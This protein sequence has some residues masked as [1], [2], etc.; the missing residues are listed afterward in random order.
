MRIG[1][2]TV[3][4]DEFPR[5]GCTIEAFQKLKPAFILDGTGTVTAGNC[6]GSFYFIKF[7]GDFRSTKNLFLRLGINDGAAALVLTSLS[8]ANRRGLRPMAR[9]V[10]WHQVGVDPLIMG[11]APIEAIRGVVRIFSCDL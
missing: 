7:I 9:I 11:I 2:I 4:E 10:A 3:S 8:E 6:S 5:K 1:D